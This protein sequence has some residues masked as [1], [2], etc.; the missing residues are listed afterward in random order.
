LEQGERVPILEYGIERIGGDKD[1]TGMECACLGFDYENKDGIVQD[2]TAAAIFMHGATSLDC[3]VDCKVPLEVTVT[4]NWTTKEPPPGFDAP[5]NSVGYDSHDSV[6]GDT[7]STITL[8]SF[9]CSGS[10]RCI[11]VGAS[12]SY[13]AGQLVTSIVRGG[14]ETFTEE[15]DFVAQNYFGC[16]GAY[17]VNPATSGA[18]IVV[19]FASTTG[20]T[21]GAISMTNV[22]QSTPVSNSNT[23][24]SYSTDPT[25]TTNSATGELCC[26]VCVGDKGLT[27]DGGQTNRWDYDGVNG[28]GNDGYC[29]DTKAGAAT[30]NF[31]WD[32]LN[33][34]WLCGAASFKEAS[35]AGLDIAIAMHH[36]KQLMGAN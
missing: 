31:L 18:N 25:V 27:P 15:W 14:S 30:V 26:A 22:D 2:Y 7:V 3:F 4:A 12:N 34:R 29:G 21:V 33:A 5:H 10:N 9:A 23:A 8:T 13:S 17:Y 16:C 35:G 28:S 19:T 20:G 11:F 6:Q 1:G 32:M 24:N 36:Y